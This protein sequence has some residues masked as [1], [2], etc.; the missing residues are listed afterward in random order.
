MHKQVIS[1]LRDNGTN[2]VSVR[3][4]LVKDDELTGR[5]VSVVLVDHMVRWLLEA[6]ISVSTLYFVGSVMALCLEN[7]F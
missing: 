3:R 6:W 5:L 2:T 1:V 4:G 7:P